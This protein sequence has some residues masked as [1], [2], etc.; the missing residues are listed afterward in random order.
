VRCISPEV[1]ASR[2]ITGSQA[3]RT[4]SPIETIE[5]RCAEPGPIA[6]LSGALLKIGLLRPM[7]SGRAT[8]LPAPDDCEPM[9]FPI[10]ATTTP[11]A[12]PVLAL[13]RTLVVTGLV[14]VTVV[15]GG[16]LLAVVLVARHGER[17]R[18]EPVAGQ[19]GSSYGQ[20]PDG[21]S[22][23]VAG[24]SPESVDVPFPLP[25]EHPPPLVPGAVGPP[26]AVAPGVAGNGHAPDGSPVVPGAAPAVVEEVPLIDRLDL[27]MS[28]PNFYGQQE[29]SA[30]AGCETA[31]P[32]V[33]LPPPFEVPGAP[34]PQQPPPFE[35][36]FEVQAPP[37]FESTFEVQA[38]PP[39]ES[40]FEAQG[41][42]PLEP[43]EVPPFE[44]LVFEPPVHAPYEPREEPP[45]EPLVFDRPTE[46]SGVG[47]FESSAEPSVVLPASPAV[48]SPNPTG[49]VLTAA[50]PMVVPA[51]SLPVAIVSRFPT[52]WVMLTGVDVPGGWT[53]DS[54]LGMPTGPEPGPPVPTAPPP[55]PLASPPRPPTSEVSSVAPAV[56]AADL[57]VQPAAPATATDPVPDPGGPDR[58]APVFPAGLLS[59]LL[60]DG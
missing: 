8:D 50:V 19:A 14:V 53:D 11:L 35:S 6:A 30:P 56:P 24:P 22:G 60:D 27:W 1:S 4:C 10:S 18:S 49:A 7:G 21:A 32:V 46:P 39:F 47:S 55:P 3:V 38:P 2:S 31:E 59:D 58:A 16:I 57:L 44:P 26:N 37:P 17:Q 29:V 13:S 12:A 34:P 45:F 54:S 41:R 15:V 28:P 33:S 40:T 9:V 43:P 48:P 25:V 42:P 5:A 51:A 20:G 23:P 36:T 52:G